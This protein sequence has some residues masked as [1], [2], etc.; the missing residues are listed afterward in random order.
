GELFAYLFPGESYAHQTLYVERGEIRS[1]TNEL[2]STQRESTFN[3]ERLLGRLR[4]GGVAIDQVTRVHAGGITLADHPMM[5]RID[6]P[7]GAF[8]KALLESQRYPDLRD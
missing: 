7:Y 1:R 4:R 8:A 3:R 6:Q 2:G 5:V